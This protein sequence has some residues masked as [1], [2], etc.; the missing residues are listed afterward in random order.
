M[1]TPPPS[2]PRFKP[3]QTKTGIME[4]PPSPAP[5]EIDQIEEEEEV[6][7]PDSH[8]PTTL[9]TEKTDTV[10]TLESPTPTKLERE[11]KI[12]G[13]PSPAPTEPEREQEAE[14]SVCSVT[15]EPERK[16]E[17][18]ELS[19]PTAA[20]PKE[21]EIEEPSS[22]AAVETEEEKEKEEAKEPPSPTAV[23]PEKEG[24]EEEE[25]EKEEGDQEPL[26]PNILLDLPNEIWSEVLWYL[27]DEDRKDFAI[28]SK[29]CY[30]LSFPSRY[31]H[32]IISKFEDGVVRVRDFGEGGWLE[33]LKYCIRSA[34]FH[35]WLKDLP[36][37]FESITVFPKL[38]DLTI[39]LATERATERNLCAA[40]VSSLSKLSFYDNIENLTFNWKT[41]PLP[42]GV[43]YDPPSDSGSET[44]GPR[45][46][47]LRR[48]REARMRKTYKRSVAR[49]SAK[50]RK[51]LGAFIDNRDLV[52]AM[53]N[54]RFPNQLRTLDLD[55]DSDDGAYALPLLKLI[56][57][58]DCAISLNS[59]A[60]PIRDYTG[61]VPELPNVKNVI[62]DYPD[63][64]SKV[65]LKY[66]AQ[67][68][69]NLKAVGVLEYQPI[70]CLEP[71]VMLPNLPNLKEI[72][73]PW[74]GLSRGNSMIHDVK[75]E[76]MK[77]LEDLI[78]KRKRV[79]EFERLEIVIVKD[80][81]EHSK[82]Q[83]LKISVRRDS[84]GVVKRDYNWEKLAS[85]KNCMDS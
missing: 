84:S 25:E 57:G 78:E 71:W 54:L 23:E 83:K 29:R 21:E 82:H 60:L 42:G 68:F 30:I 56:P 13:P 47:P 48:S 34:D 11:E 2:P 14:E 73:Y 59:S 16:E 7:T 31:D 12:E 26:I 32:I 15:A 39:S 79:G 5:T 51:F 70:D 46:K 64:N 72:V 69:P 43:E 20:E 58:I 40:V 18:E 85:W 28:C 80:W 37:A 22:P 77:A 19:P 50:E 55:I 9:E 33:P 24:K 10:E 36:E 6:E 52:T 81:G 61:A 35:F 74:S 67:Q 4:T 75:L 38:I 49:F 44:E 41:R 1:E 3:E 66:L 45:K 27:N 17:I 62:F 8:K 65:K 76:K 63:E 53:D